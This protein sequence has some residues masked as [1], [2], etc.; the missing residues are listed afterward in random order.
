M[1]DSQKKL[2]RK[3]FFSF[4]KD[5]NQESLHFKTHAHAYPTSSRNLKRENYYFKSPRSTKKFYNSSKRSF[6][7]QKEDTLKMSIKPKNEE[8]IFEM[9]RFS[10][11]TDRTNRRQY[12]FKSVQAENGELSPKSKI[13]MKIL[14]TKIEKKLNFRIQNLNPSKKISG[15]NP[16]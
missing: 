3:Y 7:G 8:D 6:N 11:G 10:L 5:Q 12:H 14:K 16:L 13:K 9:D 15:R 1:R 4:G 2:K